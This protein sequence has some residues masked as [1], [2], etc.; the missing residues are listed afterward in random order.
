MVTDY[1]SN[2]TVF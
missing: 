2:V 1:T